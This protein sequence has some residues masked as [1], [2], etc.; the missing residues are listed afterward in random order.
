MMPCP[1]ADEMVEW[2]KK[3]PHADIGVHL[4]LTSEWKN[5]AGPHL[6]MPKKFRA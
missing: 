3:H 2:T 1:Y 6:P 5:Y 4:T